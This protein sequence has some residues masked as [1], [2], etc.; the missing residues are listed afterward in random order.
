M[1]FRLTTRPL[2]RQYQLDFGKALWIEPADSFAPIAYFR[3]EVYL[4]A[5]PKQAWIQIAASDNFGLI[6]NGHTVGNL[7][8]EKTYETGIYD[9]KRALKV[10]TNVIAVSIS[11]TSYPGTAQLLLSGQIT[12]AGGNVTTILS[13]QSWR[14]SNR[15]GIVPGS[16]EWDSVHVEDEVWPRAHLS[17]LNQKAPPLRWVDTD[18]RLLRLPVIGYWIMAENAARQAVFST[19]IRPTVRN[20]KPGSKSRA[21]ATWIYPLTAISLPP[22]RKSPWAERNSPTSPPQNRHRE[23]STRLEM[24][25]TRRHRHNKRAIRSKRKPWPPT[26]SV[27]GLRKG[28]MSSLLPFEANTFPQAF[29]PMAIWSTRITRSRDSPPI[30]RGEWATGPGRI[31]PRCNAPF[32]LV[33]MESLPG[34]TCHRSWPG[35][36]TVRALRRFLSPV[37]S[38]S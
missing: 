27:I 12:E 9:F 22:R 37:W 1:S 32:K 34:A 38:S 16:V 36:S 4:N 10:G 7:G 33:Q 26:I 21:P 24:L 31:H 3:K 23:R 6:V 11:R 35:L 17:E 5:L 20:R 25:L 13:D 18:P 28:R 29:L 15:K 14:V 19:T 2:H 8:S 30:A